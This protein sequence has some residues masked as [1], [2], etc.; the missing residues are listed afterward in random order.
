METGPA[1]ADSLRILRHLAAQNL[2]GI[3]V[4]IFNRVK[5]TGSDASSAT[6]ALILIDMGKTFLIINRV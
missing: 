1:V 6:L 4:I 3:A 5:S 2:R